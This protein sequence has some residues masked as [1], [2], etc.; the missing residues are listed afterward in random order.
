MKIK[1]YIISGIQQMGVGVEE[2]EQDQGGVLVVMEGAIARPVA[3]AAV[4]M[5]PLQD[6]RQQLEVLEAVELLFPNALAS[7]PTH[8][9]DNA[10]A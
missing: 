9:G 4:L 6:R 8:A 3:V 10:Q 2:V 5:Q 1:G 7:R